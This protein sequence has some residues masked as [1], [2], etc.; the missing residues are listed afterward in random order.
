[1]RWMTDDEVRA[2]CPGW[3][4]NGNDPRKGDG[5]KGPGEGQPTGQPTPPPTPP[6]PTEQPSP[7]LAE[8]VVQKE[9]HVGDKVTYQGATYECQRDHTSQ[10]DWEPNR[11][12][13]IWK[14]I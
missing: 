8:W 3:D 1:Y 7:A 14:R 5:G 13:D 10:A 2:N 12:L 11:A 9:Y 6:P 4:W